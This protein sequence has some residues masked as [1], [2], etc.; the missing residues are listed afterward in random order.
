[1]HA[2]DCVCALS[3]HL[4]APAF[5]A[6]H[7]PTSPCRG[8]CRTCVYSEW[9]YWVQALDNMRSVCKAA[10][11]EAGAEAT[12]GVFV[13]LQKPGA[14]KTVFF[15]GPIFWA[16]AVAADTESVTVY[17]LVCGIQDYIDA[18]C[19]SGALDM[20]K[21]I[22]QYKRFCKYLKAATTCLSE[23][24]GS[25]VAK[26]KQMALTQQLGMYPL[27]DP[28]DADGGSVG[29]LKA[30]FTSSPIP[31]LEA[32]VSGGTYKAAP[33][34]IGAPNRRNGS[35]G[36]SAPEKNGVEGASGGGGDTDG[37]D[38]EREPQDAETQVVI[39]GKVMSWEQLANYISDDDK[40]KWVELQT[41]CGKGLHNNVDSAIEEIMAK[42]EDPTMRQKM[43]EW[44]KLAHKD[45][46]EAVELD[47]NVSGLGPLIPTSE[48]E[49]TADANPNGEEDEDEEVNYE[50]DEG[51]DG[52][53]EHGASKKGTKRN[54]SP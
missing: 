9:L 8:H 36:E 47:R 53:A 5:A 11:S 46:Y 31:L 29:R 51:E 1:M 52:K 16:R 34:K 19:N 24:T 27:D 22:D 35:L 42:L 32:A 48:P 12:D 54:R 26:R 25:I 7:N 37:A 2:L 33:E 45:I 40:D 18:P 23:K 13:D 44:V 38:A 17:D 30:E 3:V 20:V 41:L 10:L 6:M 15:G 49:P 50:E 21:E 39:D 14:D 43:W 28:D 4:V